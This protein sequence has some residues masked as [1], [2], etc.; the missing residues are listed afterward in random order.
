[1]PAFLTRAYAFMLSVTRRVSYLAAGVVLI[2]LAL[3]YH[4]A[5]GRFVKTV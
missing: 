3:K 2:P 4:A 1:M 5:T